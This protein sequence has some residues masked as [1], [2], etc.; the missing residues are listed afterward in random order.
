MT[1][2]SSATA[3]ST[4]ATDVRELYHEIFERSIDPIAIIDANGFYV[5]QNSAHRELTGYNDAELRGKTPAIHL[6]P[7]GFARIAMALQK[8]GRYRGV[9]ES[10]G[11]SGATRQIDIAAY[12][13]RDRDGEPIFYVG[14]KRDITEHEQLAADRDSRLRELECLYTLTR[15]LNR[16]NK[17]EEVYSAAIDAL[18]TG[19]GADRASILIYDSDN[20]MHFKSWHGL[21]DEYRKAVDGHSPWQRE[22]RNA[23]TIA[24]SDVLSDP[25]MQP[26]LPIFVREGIR[27]LAFIPIAYEDQLLGKFMVYYNHAH[28]FLP[29]EIQMAEAVATQIAVVVERRQAEETLRRSEKLA[30]AGK[31]AATV[32]H[33]INNPLEGIMNLAFLLRH[34]TVGNLAATQYLDDL[35]HE[36]KRVSLITRRTLAFYRDT[37]PPGRVELKPLI[38]ETVQLF[39]AK[40][41]IASIRVG[42]SI[43]GDPCIHGSAGEIRQV[44]LNLIANAM[45]AIGTR[46]FIE[47]NAAECE[48]HVI[49]STADTGPGID[50]TKLNRIFEPFFTTK[51]VTGTGLGLSLSREIVQRHGGS[52]AAANRPT[53]GAVITLKLPKLP[54]S[55]LRTA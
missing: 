47:I 24:V 34:E 26:Y 40:L 44:L 37:E 41:E 16:A 45:E 1:Q 32:A 3:V 30:T 48:D 22:E 15:A 51:T 5:E 4:A 55:K 14:I 28:A 23:R 35:E 6:G 43:E 54:P 19:V 52:I 12:A 49:V 21:S 39:H 36:L 13:V 53:G 20:L 18:I 27:S 33:E 25:S 9:V 11:K 7:E 50:P 42:C 10:R 31:L 29:D 38:E 8:H 17:L 46:G 2:K